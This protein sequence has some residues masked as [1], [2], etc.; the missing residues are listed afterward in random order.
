MSVNNFNKQLLIRYTESECKRQL[1]L[2]L[3]QVK[4][5]LWY[6]DTRS[7]EGIKHRRQQ[8][9]LLLHLGKIFEQKVYAHL[10]Q[11]KNVRYNVKENGE[12]DET[13]LNPQ[14]FKQFYEDLVENTDLDDILLLEFQYETPEYLINEIFPPKNNVK[15]IPVNFGEQRPDIIIIGKSFNK[16]K[17]KVF[18]LLSDGTI[19]EVPKGEFDTR[20]GIT[21]ID[22]KNI[23]EDH[24]G[25]KQF[26]EILFYLWTLSSYLKE[27]HLDDKFFVRIDFNGIFPQYSRENLKDLHTL[28]D[29]LDLT[30]QL[31]WEQANLVFLDLI[32][33]IKK[34]WKNAPL[35]IESIPVNIQ[36]SCGYCYY[37]EDCKKTL[38]IDCA[39]SDWSLQL[40]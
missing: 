1:F 21:I 35:P 39:P 34:L 3:A 18:E 5:E 38:G 25:K 32:N 8:I 27:H 15:E 33:K 24:I 13:Y 30:I 10:A 22:I 40:I 37:I 29:L 31:H 9:K 19:R 20:F 12:V 36:A 7:I 11:F 17:N 2:D 28:D 16:K 23:R 6:T 14:I 26:I 4:P